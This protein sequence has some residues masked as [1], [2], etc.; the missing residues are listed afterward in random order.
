MPTGDLELAR[1]ISGG[2]TEALGALRAELHPSLLARLRA[3]NIRNSEADDLLADMWGDC[4]PTSD[5]ETEIMIPEGTA[6]PGDEATLRQASRPSLLEKYNGRAPLRSFLFT[7][8]FRRFLDL[9]RRRQFIANAPTQSE[10]FSRTSFIQAI[11]APDGNPADSFLVE[12][13]KSAIQTAIEACPDDAWL[14]FQLV[15]LHRIPQR[16]A[17]ALWGWREY[18]TSRQLKGVKEHMKAVIELELKSKDPHLDLPWEEAL[19]IC[20][21]LDLGFMESE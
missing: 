19:D 18:E 5:D 2:D 21:T 1:Q 6:L 3:R 13:L 17:G 10:D 4:V 15:Y 9:Q 16:D 11:P 20:R 8:A 7:V 12:C 14:I